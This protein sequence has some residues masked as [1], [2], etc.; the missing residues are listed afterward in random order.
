[1][2]LRN[3]TSLRKSCGRRRNL[4]LRNLKNCWRRSLK[5]MQGLHHRLL[6]GWQGEKLPPAAAL[7]APPGRAQGEQYES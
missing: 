7:L 3:W 5:R 6:T 2:S 4:S 1:M